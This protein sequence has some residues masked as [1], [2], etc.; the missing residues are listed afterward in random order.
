MENYDF[1]VLTGASLMPPTENKRYSYFHGLAIFFRT[2]ASLVL[3]NH[4]IPLV[5]RTVWTNNLLV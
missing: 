5:C 2:E 3:K 1:S 4:P